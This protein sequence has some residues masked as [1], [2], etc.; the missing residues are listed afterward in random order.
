MDPLPKGKTVVID[1]IRQKVEASQPD[2]VEA[3]DAQQPEEVAGNTASEDE[4]D[5]ERERHKEGVDGVTHDDDSE[6]GDNGQDSAHVGVNG[7]SNEFAHAKRIK[8][9]SG[10]LLS[11]V[12]QKETSQSPDFKFSFLALAQRRTERVAG[13]LLHPFSH[14]VFGTP[15][16]LRV[17][18]LE[19][20]S[21]RDLYDLVAKR[22]R[23]FVPKSARRFLTDT[24]KDAPRE[25]EEQDEGEQESSMIPRVG[26]RKRRHR[27]TSDME[28][29]AAGPVPRYG[30]RL[31]ISSR[32]G[33]RCALCPWYECCIGCLVPDDDYPTIVMCG[34][35]LVLD[36]HFAV[37]V[38]TCGFGFRT[39]TQDSSTSQS[40]VRSKPMMVPVKNHSSCG[41]GGK[42]NGYA[43]AITL[44][45]CLDAF[46]EEERI[47]EVCY[48][49]SQCIVF[50]CSFLTL[51]LFRRIVL[52]ARTF[53]CKQNA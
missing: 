35:S 28:E 16:L 24:N 3:E 18:D 48:K 33:K 53:E 32:D 10:N 15:L 37:D 1:T 25:E 8:P 46:S 38:A 51:S 6:E 11:D 17:V 36:W 40:P 27:T 42:K 14:L 21:G 47:P 26:S 5:T 41:D 34:D 2:S 30:F 43:G 31:R 50:F 19:G 22:M 23:N 39:N 13:E 49:R 20:Y 29:V 45:D 9:D 52:I 12:E 4:S 44:E 7:A